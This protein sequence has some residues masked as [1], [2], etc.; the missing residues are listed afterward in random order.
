MSGTD[1]ITD[2]M[3][4]VA[5]DFQNDFCHP[6]GVYGTSGVF[7][8]VPVAA[9]DVV[10]RILPVLREAK[11]RRIPIVGVR[12]QV[13]TDLDG[14]G[15]GIE[16]FRPQLQEIFRERGFRQGTWGHD[17]LDEV[18]AE[19]V[20][21]DYYIDKWGHSAMYL[22][23]LEKLLRALG[24]KTLVLTGLGTNGVVEGTARDAVARGWNIWTL[25]DA[26]AAPNK[27][28]HEGAL[29]SLHHLGRTST[30]AEFLE[31]LTGSA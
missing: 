26:V 7:S 8:H 18:K 2:G 12:L 28:L 31:E 21:P 23:G 14:T 9:A 11:A 19:D 27:D 1:D 30:T 17:F 24:A 10:P 16:Q 5:M 3:V 15:I 22:T 25:T 6:D 4:I 13:W 29:N 20:A